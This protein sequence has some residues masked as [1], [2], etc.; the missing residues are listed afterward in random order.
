MIIAPPHFCQAPKNSPCFRAL[1]GHT[2]GFYAYIIFLGLGLRYHRRI[3]S[4]TAK[5]PTHFC[6]GW[7]R[8][9]QH[10][11]QDF[12]ALLHMTIC[13]CDIELIYEFFFFDALKKILTQFIP[14]VEE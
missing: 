9:S 1:S 13:C 8:Q 3:Y 4:D 11:K 5:K 7:V 14:R 2:Y 6:I 12:F 10:K